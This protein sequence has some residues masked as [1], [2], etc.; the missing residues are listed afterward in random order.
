MIQN[1]CD[2]VQVIL[3]G[4]DPNYIRNVI[5]PSEAVCIG[6]LQKNGL[7]LEDIMKKV[8]TGEIPMPGRRVFETAVNQ[9]GYAIRQ[10]PMEFQ[11]ED[12]QLLAVAS[13]PK[14]VSLLVNPTEVVQKTAL[15]A[16]PDVIGLMEAPTPE[17][18]TYA[19][20]KDPS[21]INSIEGPCYEAVKLAVERNGLNIRN[22]QNTYPELRAIA[23]SQ[24]PFIVTNGVL[25]NVSD[26]EYLQAARIN[27]NVI[28]KLSHSNP[29]LYANI[30]M[31]LQTRQ[32]PQQ[33]GFEPE[34][35]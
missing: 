17:I 28:R 11:T 24:N 29:E 19:I 1:P 31:A 32:A 22:Y 23:I 7:L 16:S 20:A 34:F 10:V 2:E 4:D 35:D 27:Q 6:V 25:K 8:R 26:E 33:E 9:N 14:V 30:Q 13:S 15:D 5:A 12:L 3:I 21:L 18:Q